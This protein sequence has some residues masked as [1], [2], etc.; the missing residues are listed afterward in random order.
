MIPGTNWATMLVR[1]E[2]P[3]LGIEPFECEGMPRH[4]EESEQKH[5]PDDGFALSPVLRSASNNGPPNKAA[6]DEPKPCRRGHCGP[7]EVRIGGDNGGERHGG[8]NFS[9]D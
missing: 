8:H 3:G 4:R 1:C 9:L 6:G 5:P 7:H 2:F